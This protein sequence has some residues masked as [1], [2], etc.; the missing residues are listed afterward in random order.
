MQVVEFC[1]ADY[2]P[3]EAFIRAMVFNRLCDP[4]SKLG[5]LR[6]LETVAMPDMPNQGIIHQHLLCS[7]DALIDHQ[8]QVDAVTA[9]L[10]RPL[11]DQDLSI[12]FYDL[13]T[14]RAEGLSQ[15]EQ[16]QEG[17]HRQFGMSKE[18]I[19]A[20]QFMLGVVQTADGLPIY[21]EVFDGNTAETRTLLPTV[22]TV[23]ARFPSINRLILVADRGLL[24]LENL[25]SLK[26]M[27]LGSGH[28]LEFIIAVPGRR[29]SEFT[30][31]LHFILDKAYTL[32][33]SA[34]PRYNGYLAW[35]VSSVGRALHF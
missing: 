10:L 15:Q 19:V 33:R 9:S 32:D 3:V 26:G 16:E 12:V 28:P 31:L 4:E 25:E 13:I 14:I 5:V 22:E 2:I 27:P 24:S 23:L 29:Y 8:E 17:D 11:I 20:R 7:M 34:P 21:H 35:V 30:E 1:R 6:W 18:G